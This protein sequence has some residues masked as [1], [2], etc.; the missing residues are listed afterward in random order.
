M[1][2]SA[3]LTFSI[4]AEYEVKDSKK[5]SVTYAI[6]KNEL[7]KD[8]YSVTALGQYNEIQKFNKFGWVVN[9]N[10]L[11]KKA[12]LE[13]L[14]NEYTN[15]VLKQMETNPLAALAAP[16]LIDAYSYKKVNQKL[17]DAGW[18]FDGESKEDKMIAVYTKDKF[19]LG[20]KISNSMF[21]PVVD[22]D[23]VNIWEK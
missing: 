9:Q 1:Q 16:G 6:Q 2:C 7:D 18:S 11:F 12:D 14:S 5:L 8:S 4:P 22:T 17:L 23:N 3:Q 15:K 20:V 19:I 21:G 13:F 10:Y